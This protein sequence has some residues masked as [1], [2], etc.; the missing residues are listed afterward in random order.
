MAGAAD[1]I[2][3]PRYDEEALAALYDVI[4]AAAVKRDAGEDRRAELRR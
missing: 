3:E 2:W 1:L 4:E